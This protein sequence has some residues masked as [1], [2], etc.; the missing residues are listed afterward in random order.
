[1]KRVLITRA[2]PQADATAALVKARG[3]QPVVM[4]LT[5]TVML[6]SGVDQVRRLGVE[7]A[8]VMVATSARAVQ[9]L[10]EADMPAFVANHRWV[11]VGQRAANLLKSVGGQLIADPARDVAGLINTLQRDV[12]LIYLCAQDRRPD[13][14]ENISFGAVIPVYEAKALG[15]FDEKAVV[16][17]H[18]N[19]LDCGLIYSAR[20][21]NLIFDALKGADLMDLVPT[22]QWFCLSDEVSRAFCARSQ[23]SI[24]CRVPHVMVAD[25]P[26]QKALLAVLGEQRT[27]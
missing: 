9:T 21:A 13:L 18:A 8:C 14:E 16:D 26:N 17:L 1:M 10:L 22:T 23:H 7:R 20:G 2:Q 6:Q 4:P 15:G 25:M 3:F 12:P 24:N 11:V 27:S 19:A 5:Q